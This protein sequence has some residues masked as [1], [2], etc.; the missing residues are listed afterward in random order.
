M[1]ESLPSA[2]LTGMGDPLSWMH[3]VAVRLSVR[4]S[5]APVTWLPRRD[6]LAALRWDEPLRHEL[7]TVHLFAHTDRVE[8][9]IWTT[10][11]SGD[12]VGSWIY[13][14]LVITMATLIIDQYADQD[15]PLI[16]LH[17]QPY[18][19]TQAPLKELED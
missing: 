11:W 3:A 5:C 19:E 17:V 2:W 18:D 10:A 7:V 13:H 6:R 1:D 4:P 9:G 15:G 14:E 8:I 16:Q 12:Q